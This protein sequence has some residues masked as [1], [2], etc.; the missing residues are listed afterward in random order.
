MK[1]A[2]T[3]E[4]VLGFRARV[5]HLDRAAGTSEPLAPAVLDLGVQETGPDGGRWALAI[6]GVDPAAIP[7]DELILLWTIR[8]A[9]HWY[10]RRDLARVAAAVA[11]FSDADAGKRIYDASK[12]LREAGIDNLTALDAVAA[13]MR[14]VVTKPM[15]KGEVSTRLTALMDP[16]YLRF[17]RPCDTTHLYEMPFRLAAVRAGLQLTPNTS[18]PV[19]A[20]IRRFSPAAEPG[21]DHDVIRGYLRLLG[22]ATPKHVADYLD[23]PVKEVRGRWPDDVTEVTV[24]GERRWLLTE[25]VPKLAAGPVTLTR[26]LGPFDLFL[27]AKDRSLLV[28]QPAR[29]KTLWPVLG[30]PGAVLVDGDIVGVWRPRQSSGTLNVQLDLWRR[31]S[32][33]AR[34]AIEEQ[35]ER[36][37]DYR[38]VTLGSVL[39]DVV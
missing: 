29:S 14:T 2:V 33:Q 19:L 17:C 39:S 27:Q 10:R 35:A 3:R 31:V 16:P 13:A 20:P 1:S 4:Q 36:L 5:Q 25:D 12:P 7:E 15:V 24:A 6:R 32:A 8:G 23:A 37:A 38:G 26:L 34:A 22:P 11:P 21:P 30:R 18:P 28:E 9:P